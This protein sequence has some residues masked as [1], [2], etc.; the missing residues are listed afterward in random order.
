MA[1]RRWVYRRCGEVHGP[2][3]ITDLRAAAFLGFLKPND[4]VRDIA[5]NTWVAAG[6]IALLGTAFRGGHEP[7]KAA[8]MT[9]HDRPPEE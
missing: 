1:D 5:S 8:P 7:E 4:L 2:L 3:D 9:A 6:S